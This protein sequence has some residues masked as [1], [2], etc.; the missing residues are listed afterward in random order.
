MR[1][2]VVLTIAMLFFGILPVAQ[3]LAIGIT[4]EQ[5]LQDARD[6]FNQFQTGKVDR[7]RLNK[8]VN[9]H[10]SRDMIERESRTLK[11]FG[12]PQRFV[13]LGTNKVR[14]AAGYN[15]LVIFEAARIIESIAFDSD[16]KVAGVDFQPY[17]PSKS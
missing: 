15:F 7:A 16:G 12:R 17:L 9:I 6:W 4:N 10:L 3:C 8:Q 5:A 1:R 2:A 11:A 14:G 13:F